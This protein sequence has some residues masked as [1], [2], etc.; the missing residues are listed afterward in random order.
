MN[1]ST[2]LEPGPR[3]HDATVRRT[4]DRLAKSLDMPRAVV[5]RTV[6][7][8]LE[9]RLG[10]RIQTFVPIFAERAARVRLAN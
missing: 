5:E 7:S 1:Q 4:T 6:R 3:D 8:E 9:R 10:S 2:L